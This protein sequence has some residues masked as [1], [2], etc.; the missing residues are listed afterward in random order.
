MAAPILTA[1]HVTLRAH[2]GRDAT[3][4]RCL[5]RLPPQGHAL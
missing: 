3:L 4:T 5:R 1:L 2:V